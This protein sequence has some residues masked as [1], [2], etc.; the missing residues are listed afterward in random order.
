[1]RFHDFFNYNVYCADCMS[2]LGLIFWI[3]LFECIYQGFRKKRE[4]RGFTLGNRRPLSTTVTL[5][6]CVTLG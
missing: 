4:G 1:M 2:S 6:P 3:Y 5:V